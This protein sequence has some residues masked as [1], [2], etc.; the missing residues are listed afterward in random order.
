MSVL[1]REYSGQSVPPIPG[2]LPD[3][4]AGA[5]SILWRRYRNSKRQNHRHKADG[6]GVY[7]ASVTIVD[8]TI[9]TATDMNGNFTLQNVPVKSRK[10]SVSIVGYSPESQVDKNSVLSLLCRNIGN[11]QYEEAQWFPAPGKSY[12]AGMDFTL[13]VISET[14]LQQIMITPSQPLKYKGLALF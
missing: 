11:V 12:V 9:G 6:E 13:Q 1:L 5:S 14:V 10:V 8:T 7:G 3:G 2:I 4:V